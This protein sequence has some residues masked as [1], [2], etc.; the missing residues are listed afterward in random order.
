VCQFLG[1]ISYGVFLWQFMVLYLWRDFTGQ[2]IF[3][4]SFWLDAVPVT[5]GTVLLAAASHR[6][7]EEPSRRWSHRLSRR[8]SSP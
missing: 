2:E 1:R 7:V 4:G 6:W 8:R 3:T 5:I